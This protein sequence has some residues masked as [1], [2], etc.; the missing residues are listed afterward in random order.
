MTTAN[1]LRR[2]PK[3]Q[4]QDPDKSVLEDDTELE[5]DIDNKILAV[6]RR[7]FRGDE[8]TVE[9]WLQT[10]NRALDNVPPFYFVGTKAGIDRVAQVLIDIAYGVCN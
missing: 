5:T 7:I 2:T 9:D 6:A 10:P 3:Q 4:H 8:K 1:I